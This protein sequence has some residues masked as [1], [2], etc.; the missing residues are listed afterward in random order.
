MSRRHPLHFAIALALASPL[1]AALAQD[2]QPTTPG[3]D[4]VDL[5][6]VVVRAQYESQVRAIDLKRSSDAIQDTVSSDSMGQYP[7]KNVGESLSRLPGAFLGNKRRHILS[8][9]HR[10]GAGDN[11]SAAGRA[12]R[13][14]CA[15]CGNH[16]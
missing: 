1:P 2:P 4:A 8:G 16:G 12:Y 5:D 9:G 13:R 11:G 10:R 14:K 6:A 7:D 15:R 3:M